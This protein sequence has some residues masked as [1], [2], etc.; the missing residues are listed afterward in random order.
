[1][2]CQQDA[3]DH[4][5][6]G[7][8]YGENRTAAVQGFLASCAVLGE[9]EKRSKTPGYADYVERRVENGEKTSLKI[10]HRQVVACNHTNRSQD[11]QKGGQSEDGS[12]K[13]FDFILHII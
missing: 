10:P 1:M 9:K 12:G 2:K 7:A 5:D 6:G 8:C 13:D 11:T 3:A 4:E